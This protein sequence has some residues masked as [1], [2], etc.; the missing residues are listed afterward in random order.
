MFVIKQNTTFDWPV[1]A[2][3]PEGGKHVTV[4]FTAQFRVI[5]HKYVEEHRGDP[6]AMLRKALVDFEGDVLD[7]EGQPVTDPQARCDIILAQSNF[8]D[9]L[10]NAYAEGLLG[11]EA[12]N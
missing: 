8:L 2:R 1:K 9:A 12:K 7:A 11:Y 6:A 4:T 10:S 5:D 3:M